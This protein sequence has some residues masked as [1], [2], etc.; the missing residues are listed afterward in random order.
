MSKIKSRISGAVIPL[1]PLSRRTL[2]I[3]R[4]ESRAART[5]LTNAINLR[6][7]MQMRKLRRARDLSINFGSGG[8]GLPSWVNVELRPHKDTT[9]CLDIRRRLPFADGSARRILAEHVVEHLDFRKDVPRLL[10]EFYRV[11]APR[12]VAR[13]I[14]PDAQRFL[15]AYVTTDKAVWQKLG[16][17]IDNLPPD[18]YTSMHVINHIFHQ[19]GEHLFG[20][21]FVTLQWV[22]ENAGFTK[23]LRQKFGVSL[24]PELAIDQEIHKLYSLY[25]E[26]VR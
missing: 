15:E 1:L 22:L 3:L 24:D 19:G 20:Y 9:I 5:T 23:I 21:D 11:L 8:F 14:V 7:R 18:I 4:H 12:G 17:D 16:W 10:G 26:V 25:V 13:I 2:D 6:Y